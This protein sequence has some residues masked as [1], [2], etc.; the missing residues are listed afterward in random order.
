MSSWNYTA[1]NVHKFAAFCFL[2]SGYLFVDFAALVRKG[3]KHGLSLAFSHDP[4][5]RTSKHTFEHK[6]LC[7]FIE[8]G[9]RGAD[10]TFFSVSSSRYLSISYHSSSPNT[11]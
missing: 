5:Q 11:L 8:G 10:K 1:L 9:E 3:R 2:W 4:D 6:C 7:S